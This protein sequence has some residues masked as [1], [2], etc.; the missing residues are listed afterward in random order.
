MS[1]FVLLF[2]LLSGSVFAGTAEV[3]AATYHATTSE[4]HVRFFTTDGKNR[5]VDNVQTDDF[6]IVDGDTVIREFRSLSRSDETG[7]ELLI[8]VDA[9]ESVAPRFKAIIDEV[10]KFVAQKQV[11]GDDVSVASFAGLHPSVICAGDCRSD[12]A[13]QSLLALKPAGATPLFDALEYGARFISGRR[14]P[15]LRPVVILFSD[16]DDTISM[17]SAEDALQALIDSGALLNTIDVNKPGDF[18]DGSAALQ[19][20]A[21]TTGGRSFSIREGAENVLKSILED[22]Q[23]SYLVTYPL[24]ST[25][26]GFHTLRMLPKRNLNLRFHCRNGYYYGTKIP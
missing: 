23:A 21:E 3:P 6:A 9:S 4:V 24:P 8:M 10:L 22:L 18:S 14:T 19:R 2:L 12:A 20:M 16:G 17:S 11:A 15:G 7:L 5:P 25:I 13:R 26:A 1:R